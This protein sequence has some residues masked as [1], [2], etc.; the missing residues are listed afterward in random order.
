ME[1]SSFSPDVTAL[2]FYPWGELKNIVY[3]EKPAIPR[4]EGKNCSCMCNLGQELDNVHVELIERFRVR[5]E[6]DGRHFGQFWSREL[7]MERTASVYV[8]AAA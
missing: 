6:V 1:W 7:Q 5:V 2:A 8:R 4:Y 3:R